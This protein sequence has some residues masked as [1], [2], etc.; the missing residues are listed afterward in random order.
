MTM[1]NFIG[2]WASAAGTPK[3]TAIIIM[4]VDNNVFFRSVFFIIQFEPSLF[5]VAVKLFKCGIGLSKHYII[6]QS[7]R[8]VLIIKQHNIHK[9]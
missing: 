9:V 4:A 8:C 3:A 7:N 2:I 1:L 5:A 6:Y